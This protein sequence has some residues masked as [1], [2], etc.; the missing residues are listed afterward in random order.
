MSQN[1]EAAR[2][3]VKAKGD[4]GLLEEEFV[5][6]LRKA[7]DTVL[8]VQRTT[9]HGEPALDLVRQRVKF[10]IKS[11]SKKKEKDKRSKD[12]KDSK[13]SSKKADESGKSSKDQDDAGRSSDGHVP[14]NEPLQ[15]G[16]PEKK[17]LT[18]RND[19]ESKDRERPPTP[20]PK[21]PAESFH[22]QS[23]AR[24][25][26]ASKVE[27]DDGSV[28]SKRSSGTEGSRRK[29][30]VEEDNRSVISKRSSGTEGSR[31][32]PQ[33]EEDNRS[34]ISKR[35]SGTEGSRR[36]PQ[37]EE[38]NR[39]VISKRSSG[40]EGSRR[41]PKVERDDEQD[42]EQDNENVISKSSLG[43][44]RSGRT[45]RQPDVDGT[46]GGSRRHRSDNASVIED[47]GANTKDIDKIKKFSEG[48]RELNHG[49]ADEHY[50]AS[51]AASIPDVA[52]GVVTNP[53]AMGNSTREIPNSNENLVKKQRG[54]E[55]SDRRPRSSRT[56]VKHKSEASRDDASDTTYYDAR[57]RDR[58]PSRSEQSSRTHKTD[59][60]YYD[61][62]D[63]SPP[64][65]EKSSRTLKTDTVYHSVRGSSRDRASEANSLKKQK[66]AANDGDDE[67]IQQLEDRDAE[68]VALKA[69]LEV[70]QAEASTQDSVENAPPAA[71][72][73]GTM[74]TEKESSTTSTEQKKR[75]GSKQRKR[76][77]RKTNA[78]K[79]ST[80]R[81]SDSNATA[82]NNLV[83]SSV[84][85][86]HTD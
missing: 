77:E 38:D 78:Q 68:L 43:T 40:T 79:S 54:G 66:A 46:Q 53:M 25:V 30:Q 28:I 22:T 86:E 44:H 2:A 80:Q 5:K 34:V 48:L 59:T 47:R 55:A 71:T 29:L 14:K 73:D 39:S 37:V 83:S 65:S 63:R 24:E 36:K 70:L 57:D 56:E 84:E 3:F 69:Q 1:I 74:N 9:R 81:A 16:H 60:T 50:E 21:I 58:S 7:K 42:D 19:D 45:A 18:E 51:R 76:L 15:L 12:S 11:S 41:K 62:R 23:E 82:E 13:H 20:R 67:V 75:P 85:V 72:T 26:K 27:R 32:K 6:G 8:Y 49:P 10:E 35:S 4:P 52:W 17:I 33:V 64:R 31:R 61:A